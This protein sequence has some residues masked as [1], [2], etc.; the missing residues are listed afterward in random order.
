MNDDDII[1][2]DIENENDVDALLRE[3]ELSSIVNPDSKLNGIDEIM[4]DLDDEFLEVNPLVIS[5]QNQNHPLKKDEENTTTNGEK[6]NST[7]MIINIVI[8]FVG[9][10]LLGIPQAFS[11]S[12]WLL[13]SITLLIVSALN[14]YA[15]L[16]LPHVQEIILE[17]HGIKV[18]TYSDMG[19]VILGKTGER[20]IQMCLMISQAGFSTAYII[21]I[22]ANLQSND[23]PRIWICLFC[24]PGL[25]FLCHVKDLSTL[26][27]FSLLANCANFAALFAVLSQD[28]LRIFSKEKQSFGN[29]YGQD[30]ISLPTFEFSGFLYVV[31]VTIY[32]MEGIGLIL[33]LKNSAKEPENF[34]FLL[35][36]TVG[37]ISLFF[38]FFASWGALA[39]G[40]NTE[41]PITLNLSDASDMNGA[42]TTITVSRFV[43]LSLCLGL[44]LT[45]PIMMFPVWTILEKNT[46]HDEEEKTILWIRVATVCFSSFVAYSVPNFGKFLELVGS[47]VCTL[48]AFIFPCYFHLNICWTEMNLFQKILDVILML[49]AVGFAIMGTIESINEL[50]KGDE[51]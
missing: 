51:E 26:S 16:R 50:R 18:E 30:N 19:R 6:A 43:K 32:S 47:S 48:L 13:G 22:C 28:F 8:S 38:A 21:F 15:M 37:A 49:G 12:G 10:G 23:L 27:P 20:V 46:K 34:S 33:P 39:F 36:T 45:Y 24:V 4:N 1:E 41:S 17:K 42:T 40:E 3:I 44:F 9:A 5:D 11:K 7:Q 35:K 2:N 29:D 14:I 31:A 25:G